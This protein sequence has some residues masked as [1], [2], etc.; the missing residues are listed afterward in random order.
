MSDGGELLRERGGIVVP[1]S[2][3]A[4]STASSAR[5]FVSL[6]SSLLDVSF[7]PHNLRLMAVS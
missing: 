3:E 6:T 1:R 5:D 4:M 2:E 7:G